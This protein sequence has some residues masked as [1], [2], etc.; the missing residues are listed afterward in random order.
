[1]ASDRNQSP[2]K[3]E[4]PSWPTPPYRDIP[5]RIGEV[6]RL[7]YEPPQELPHQL[8]TLL[9]QVTGQQEND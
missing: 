3:S 7:Q 5:I 6:L 9:M 8:F 2:I 4:R 1:M